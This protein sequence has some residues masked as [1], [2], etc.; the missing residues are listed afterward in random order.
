MPDLRK[1][2]EI[3]DA[4]DEKREMYAKNVR[5]HIDKYGS[6]ECDYLIHRRLMEAYHRGA[7]N[8]I[9]EIERSL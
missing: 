9:L 4:H 3:K 7:Y 1:I 8:A 6:R 5:D 2:Q